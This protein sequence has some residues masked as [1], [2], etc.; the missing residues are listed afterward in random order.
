MFFPPEHESSPGLSTKRDEFS[1]TPL[2][3]KDVTMRDSF[4]Q[5]IE[6]GGEGI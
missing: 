6:F 3:S 1:K 5:G 4:M 2:T